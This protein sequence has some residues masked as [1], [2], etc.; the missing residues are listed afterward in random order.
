MLVSDWGD[1]SLN[2]E[3]GEVIAGGAE[4]VSAML[5]EDDK[6]AE[7]PNMAD[8]SIV[9]DKKLG[10]ASS[11]SQDVCGTRPLILVQIFYTQVMHY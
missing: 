6:A 10:A 5:E 3:T 8:V 1:W 11:Q 9:E 2:N 4:Q 7:V